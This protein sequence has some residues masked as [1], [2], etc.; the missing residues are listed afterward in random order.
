MFYVGQ[1]KTG[2]LIIRC[3]ISNLYWLG[4]ISLTISDTLIKS[5][6]TDNN[7]QYDRFQGS[8]V[9]MPAFFSIL[10][11][12]RL[13][14]S[15]PVIP[16]HL[17][18]CKHLI[19]HLINRCAVHLHEFYR[20]SCGISTSPYPASIPNVPAIASVLYHQ[21]PETCCI[22][23]QCIGLSFYNIFIRTICTELILLVSRFRAQFCHQMQVYQASMYSYNALSVQSYYLFLPHPE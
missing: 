15:R 14:S 8:P 2:Q 7:C 18:S 12:T 10:F 9:Y 22:Q 19:E 17:Q 6:H 21:L 4:L 23:I 5:S 1:G 11:S 20:E 13:L 3:N 16:F